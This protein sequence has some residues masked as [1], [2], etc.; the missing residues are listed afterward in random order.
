MIKMASDASVNSR[1][2]I[3]NTVMERWR[4]VP[5]V[6]MQSIPSTWGQG[7]STAGRGGPRPRAAG[8]VEQLP[9]A[10]GRTPWLL[11]RGVRPPR[12]RCRRRARTA[13]RS[14][15]R[16]R[17]G[18]GSPRTPSPGC[19]RRRPP[20]AT[21]ASSTP[22][23]SGSRRPASSSPASTAARSGSPGR[24][25]V[26]HGGEDGHARPAAAELQRP[27]APAPGVES[28]GLGADDADAPVE[29]WVEPRAHG[30]ARRDP[31]GPGRPAGAC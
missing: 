5:E 22:S 19:R 18:S 31:S 12:R 25:V 17:L 26:R 27:T 4:S 10:R 9:R 11:Q 16:Q 2:G 8:I 23:S 15:R 3:A 1:I 24:R 28:T 21:A 14:R 7:D 20:P 29:A 13:R 30:D 6:G